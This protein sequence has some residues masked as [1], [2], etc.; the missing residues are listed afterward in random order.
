MRGACDVP[1]FFAVVALA[2]TLGACSNSGAAIGNF[3]KALP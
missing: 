1:S 2:S 3:Y